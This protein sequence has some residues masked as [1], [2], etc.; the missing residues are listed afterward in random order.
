[1]HEVTSPQAF[2]GL[3]LNQR[4]RH[5]AKS[6][7]ATADHNV[8]TLDQKNGISDPES[9]LQVDTLDENCRKYD[10]NYFPLG[11]PRQGIVHIAFQLAKKQK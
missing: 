11:D 10:L 8:P 9:K 5:Q 3:H 1:M 2:E 6:I 4:K 7:L